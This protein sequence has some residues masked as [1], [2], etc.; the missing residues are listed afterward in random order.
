MSRLG[1]R[2]WKLAARLRG[3]TRRNNRPSRLSRSPAG[4]PARRGVA[5][6]IVMVVVMM[7]S[8][9]A[10]GYNHQM[11]TAY[12]LSRQHTERAQAR[13]AALSGI[14][15]MLALADLPEPIRQ[16]RLQDERSFRGQLVSE[17]GAMGGAEA[18]ETWSFTVVA[19]RL[20][21]EEP[22]QSDPPWR[23]GLTHES[24]KL[25]VSMLRRQERLFPGHARRTLLGLPGATVADVDAFLAELNLL[26]APTRRDLQAEL[27]ERTAADPGDPTVRVARL[28]TGGD[29]DHNERIERLER[30][31]SAATASSV[32]NAESPTVAS[33]ESPSVASE[34]ARHAWRNYLTFHS[35]R[36]NVNRDGRPRI[37]LNA[38]NLRGLHRE[39]STLWS[40]EHADFVILARQHGTVS[41]PP[42]VPTSGDAAA[43]KPVIDFGRAAT[44]R[45]ASPLDLIGVA[46]RLPGSG[47]AVRWVRS[48][49]RETAET[50]QLDLDSL[51]DDVTTES[52]AVL[53]GQIDIL[54]APAGV[55]MGIPGMTASLAAR[56]IESR[57]AA[58]A[59]S[60]ASPTVAWLVT[61]Q[62]ISLGTLREWYPW[63]TVGGDC[64][65][66]QAIGYR[67]SLSP[68]FRTTFVI[69]AR[70]GAARIGRF[71]HWHGWGHGF[72]IRQLRGDAPSAVP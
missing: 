18:D 19:P 22:S 16:Q 3:R 56:V 23:F 5:L 17:S 21:T 35:G 40:E 10:Y 32:A 25:N 72:D 59:E 24:A 15:A 11:V 45:L 55:L 51:V 38:A 31:V 13:L 41:S 14:E 65:G 52:A 39:L 1:Y 66:G 53:N 71:Q 54:R 8:L 67:D 61:R 26:P 36:R 44:S 70:Y 62:V 63:I 49:F 12:R 47:S 50:G 20:S 58:A 57:Q 6:V 60:A 43:E 68:L 34:A 4:A 33:T 29:W 48:P 2:D 37:D 30:M 46:V 69:D 64:Y 27:I 7:L 28:W 9:A 42:S